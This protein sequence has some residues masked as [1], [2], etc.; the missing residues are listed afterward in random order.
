MTRPVTAA[1]EKRRASVLAVLAT[2]P[3]RHWT[4]EEVFMRV[5][6]EMIRSQVSATLGA[7]RADGKILWVGPDRWQLAAQREGEA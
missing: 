6:R 5:S 4:K 2:D 3:G 7:L 1:G